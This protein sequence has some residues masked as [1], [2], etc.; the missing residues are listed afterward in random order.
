MIFNCGVHYLMA[1][2]QEAGLCPGRSMM[3]ECA[4]SPLPLLV[5][6]CPVLLYTVSLSHTCEGV[7]SPVRGSSLERDPPL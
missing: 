6:L 2:N 3:M 5:G 4:F 7:S 1:T